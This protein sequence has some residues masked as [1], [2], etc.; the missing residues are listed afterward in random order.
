M[1][2]GNK[3]ANLLGRNASNCLGIVKFVASIELNEELFGLGEW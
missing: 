1:M 2:P 3:T